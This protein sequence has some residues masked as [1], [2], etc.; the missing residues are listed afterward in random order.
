MGRYYD[1]GPSTE[2]LE[3]IGIKIEDIGPLPDVELWEENLVVWD[4]FY[5]VGTQWRVGMAGATGLDYNVLPFIFDVHEIK[6]E[7]RREVLRFLRVMELE[8][9]R[10]GREKSN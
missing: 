2:E 4:V 10:I 6:N 7:D 1:P 9:L 3:K 8:A 5:A